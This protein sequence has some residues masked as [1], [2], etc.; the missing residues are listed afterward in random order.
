[1]SFLAGIAI[2]EMFTP[3]QFHQIA[4]NNYVVQAWT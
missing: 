1:M 3:K 4:F 2:I